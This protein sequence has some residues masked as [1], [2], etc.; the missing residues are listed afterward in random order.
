MMCGHDVCHSVC[1][2]CDHVGCFGKDSV[3]CEYRAE[4][5]YESTHVRFAA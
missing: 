4:L 1:L 2:S 3:K 5:H